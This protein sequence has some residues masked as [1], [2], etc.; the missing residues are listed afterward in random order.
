MAGQV[1]GRMTRVAIIALLCWQPT[2]AAVVDYQLCNPHVLCKIESGGDVAAFTDPDVSDWLMDAYRAGPS[3]CCTTRSLTVVVSIRSRSRFVFCPSFFLTVAR[4]VPVCSA[5][6][7]VSTSSA[8]LIY[9][10]FH[11]MSL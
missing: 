10:F 1:T 7:S 2:P 11:A 8:I 9:L 6:R 3:Q 4:F 5:P